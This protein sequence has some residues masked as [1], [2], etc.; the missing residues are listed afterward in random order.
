MKTL[1]VVLLTTLLLGCGYKSPTQSAPQAGVVPMV[2]ALVPNSMSAGSAGFTLTVNGSNF[3]N[4]AV[5]NWNGAQQATTHVT[6]NQ[7]TAAIPATDI[8][9]AGSASVSVTN[10]GSSTPGGPYG[11]GVTTS[12]ETSA[13]VTFTIQ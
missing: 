13:S 10:P 11:G 3:N 12:S 1:S 9:T 4:N 6:P 5:V 2:S 8:A 7:L